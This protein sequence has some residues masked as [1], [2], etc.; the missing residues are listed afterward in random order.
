[1]D[2]PEVCALIAPRPLA[3]IDAIDDQKTE[4]ALDKV[5]HVY[6]WT[7]LAYSNLRGERHFRIFKDRE[8]GDVVSLM[9]GPEA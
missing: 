8:F 2:V 6:E 7:S 4:L 5:Q 9:I 1:M 3:I